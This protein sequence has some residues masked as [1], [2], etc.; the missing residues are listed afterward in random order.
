MRFTL[1]PVGSDM[2]VGVAGDGP[3]A[4][5]RSY[6]ARCRA[7]INDGSFGLIFFSSSSTSSS[8]PDSMAVS[9]RSSSLDALSRF[10]RFLFGTIPAAVPAAADVDGLLPPIG[11]L[12]VLM[13]GVVKDVD[14]SSTIS[15]S[16]DVSSSGTGC[17][18]TRGFLCLLLF[19][20]RLLDDDSVAAVV[21]SIY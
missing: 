20:W 5:P 14:K 15:K 4:P 18:D 17:C 1:Y 3:S 19:L 21:S 2:S 9:Q 12:V 13:M 8:L 6:I 11:D 16:P 7:V 10:L